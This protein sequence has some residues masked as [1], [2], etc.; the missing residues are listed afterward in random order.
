MALGATPS[1]VLKLILQ[2]GMVLISAGAALGLVLA[3]LFGRGLASLLYGVHPSDP[4]SLLG[5][6]ILF[7][8]VGSIAF[9]IPAHRAVCIDPMVALRYE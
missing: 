6:V 9:Y 1:G 7:V 5:A 4:I 8:A 3:Y 2:E